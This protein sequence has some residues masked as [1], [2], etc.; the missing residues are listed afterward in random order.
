MLVFFI[1]KLLRAKKHKKK[2][3][4]RKERALFKSDAILDLTKTGVTDLLALKLNNTALVAAEMAGGVILGKDYL[5]ALDVYL[6]RVGAC[7]IHLLTHFLGNN[8]SAELV[9]VSNYTC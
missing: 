6:D 9:Y 3:T 4:H 1:K 8:D 5:V 7:D 2:S